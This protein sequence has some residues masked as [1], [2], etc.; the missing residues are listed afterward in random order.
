LSFLTNFSEFLSNDLKEYVK[1]NITLEQT[2][3]D[4]I[5]DSLETTR[6][7]YKGKGQDKNKVYVKE[8]VKSDIDIE[9]AKIQII[10]G[11]QDQELELQTSKN[12][13]DVF[14]GQTG[15]TCLSTNYDVS[16]IDNHSFQPITIINK[17]TGLAEG[18]I[19]AY[20]TDIN[21]KKALVSLGIEPKIRLV[22]KSVSK[23]ELTEKL[24]DALKEIARIN[25]LDAVYISGNSG[26][27]SNRDD[28]SKILTER[29]I[30][31]KESVSKQ[32]NF[33]NDKKERMLYKVT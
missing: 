20:V 1:E 8:T 7:T 15:E 4:K 11:S 13:L 19:Y 3:I 12:I 24:I 9:R 14:C 23:T 30:T 32:I 27:V 5:N 16:F 17:Q 21:H 10:G 18:C 6:M 33:P 29:Y 26:E 22:N 2:D 31:N 25:K 28:V